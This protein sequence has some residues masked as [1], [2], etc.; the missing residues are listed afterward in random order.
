M[1]G[2]APGLLARI[3]PC[4]PA[5]MCSSGTRSGGSTEIS[6]LYNNSCASAATRGHDDLLPR[7]Y[8]NFSRDMRRRRCTLRLASF[9]LSETET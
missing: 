4:R 6:S 8:V 2:R 5:T 1:A 3:P 9:L 7:A